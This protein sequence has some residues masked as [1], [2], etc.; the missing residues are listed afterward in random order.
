[1]QCR[2]TVASLA[3]NA[4][5]MLEQKIDDLYPVTP[6]CGHHRRIT[7]VVT[8]IDTDSLFDQIAYGLDSSLPGRAQ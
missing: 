3:V 8:G 1:M 2:L 6:G 5:A 7:N 4:C